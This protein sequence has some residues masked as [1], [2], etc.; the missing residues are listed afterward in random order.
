MFSLNDC[1]S[2][3]KLMDAEAALDKYSANP[4]VSDSSKV[5]PSSIFCAYKGVKIDGRSY[6]DQAINNGASFVLWEDS[7]DY[8]FNHNIANYG[9]EHLAKYIGLIVAYK[10]HN[11]SDKFEQIIGVTGTNGKT[12]ITHWLNQISIQLGKVS[13]IIGTT[14]AGIY[15]HIQDCAMTTPDPITLQQLLKQL[16]EQKTQ[17]LAMEVSS[18]SLDQGRVNGVGYEVAIFTNL[19]QDHLDYHKDMEHYYLAKSMLF[20]WDS[21]KVA[22]I[23][24]DDH[25]GKRLHQELTTKRHELK[26]LTYAINQVSDVMASNVE[27]NLSGVSFDL[28]YLGEVVKIQVPVLGKFNVYN[29]LAVASYLIYQ[30]ISLNQIVKLL[31]KL[32][33]VTG[34][35]QTIL[36]DQHPKVVIDYAHTPDALENVLQSL[37]VVE[38]RGKLICVFGCG[39]DRDHTKRPIMGEIS[40]K[41]SDMVIVTSDNPR[42]EDPLSIIDQI[43]SGMNNNKYQVIEDRRNAIREALIMA[44]PNDIVLIAGKGHETYQEIKGIKHH[45]SDYEEVMRVFN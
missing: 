26:L 31:V 42:S 38:G 41:Y 37:S 43:T 22:I 19:T 18:H 7:Q 34:R 14:G 23:N 10:Y 5:V 27:I 8:H 32:T 30:N 15:P 1:I 36:I 2:K 44:K 11:P 29:L 13:A 3:N 16:S 25:Y 12:S 24:I 17:V 28:N 21:L 9:I 39:G 40:Q 6:I 20:Y 33:P 4:I 35:M 45:F